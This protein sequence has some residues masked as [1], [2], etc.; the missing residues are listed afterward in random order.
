MQLCYTNYI[1][2]KVK[3]KTK[4]ETKKQTSQTKNPIYVKKPNQP[5]QNPPKYY[6]ILNWGGRVGRVLMQF[7]MILWG[8]N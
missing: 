4:K 3:I 6:N 8:K 7:C 1:F 5:N 2:L